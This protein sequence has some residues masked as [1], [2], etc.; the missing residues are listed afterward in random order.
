M[1]TNTNKESSQISTEEMQKM[2]TE[3]IEIKNEIQNLLKIQ[4]ILV[5]RVIEI[6]E[7]QHGNDQRVEAMKDV[8]LP[9]SEEIGKL[10]ILIK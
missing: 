6:S 7:A 2:I 4:S 10:K 1:E 8:I 3:H 9:L 5:T